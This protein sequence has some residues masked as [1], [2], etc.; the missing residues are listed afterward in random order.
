VTIRP[1]VL[2][3]FIVLFG[4]FARAGTYKAPLLDHHSWRQADTASIARNFY[5]ERLNILYPQVDQRGAR[6][7]GYVETTMR[8]GACSAPRSSSARAC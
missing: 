7:V 4:F 5:R 1:S 8:L 6:Q 2:L 3:T